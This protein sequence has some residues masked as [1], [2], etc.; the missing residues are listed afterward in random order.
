MLAA[1]PMAQT[2]PPQGV[3][4]SSVVVGRVRD[5]R[6]VPVVHASVEIESTDTQWG[7]RPDGARPVL[8]LR[9]NEDGEFAFT[10][11]P[12]GAYAISARK[13]GYEDSR[14]ERD[15]AAVVGRLAIRLGPSERRLDVTLQLRQLAS[16]TGVVTDDAGEP[17]TP[18]NV[19]A[20]R[21]RIVSGR[22]RFD[23]AIGSRFSSS[24][25]CG[26]YRGYWLQAG[27][28]IFVAR[29]GSRTL[30]AV[31]PDRVA[32]RV[33]YS[34]ESQIAVAPDGS[35]S[36]ITL[37][38]GQEMSNL[39]FRLSP[40]PT[41]RISGT[42]VGGTADGFMIELGRD[43]PAALA[44]VLGGGSM[45]S[46][47]VQPDGRFA[48]EGVTPGRY[49]LRATS[50]PPGEQPRPLSAPQ[51]VVQT[52][53][54]TITASYFFAPP[55]AA[56]PLPQA[57]PLLLAEQ[58]VT[59][60]SADLEG[61]TLS[62]R[63]GPLMKGRII[64]DGARPAPDPRRITYTQIVVEPADG[65]MYGRGQ[66]GM[67]VAPDGRFAADHLLRGRY[68]LRAMS[69]DDGWVL[70]SAMASGKDLSA[71]SFDTGSD[72]LADVV[73]TFT[74]RPATIRG[75]ASGATGRAGAI[76]VVLFPVDSRLWV[77]YGQS[78]TR[79][80]IARADDAGAF[81]FDPPPGD[82]YILAATIPPGRDWMDAANLQRLSA[83]AGRASVSE[84]QRVTVNL[85]ARPIG[86]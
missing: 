71:E 51:T 72:D 56:P 13:D 15:E 22:P 14:Y 8:S 37:A 84:G 27:E 4:G 19:N 82:Y 47:A 68:V 74:D 44:P 69:A 16:V 64:F 43:A 46:L 66:A 60:G 50:R 80:N 38:A 85:Q 26:E 1:A 67:V 86:R 31:S 21:R 62:L 61:I 75:V 57:Q 53:A 58:T 24:N 54:G 29:A 33:V 35:I 40:E 70:R 42:V 63:P 59:V 5:T 52:S 20:Y 25:D 6:G 28:Y 77:D 18:A 48:F 23:T 11:L 45:S 81:A 2:R 36:T 76:W 65:A 7:G 78:S 49:R 55:P 30:T 32:Q 12:A 34:G 9:T 17:L 83:L 10:G 79:I 3:K 39:D 73:V 41:V